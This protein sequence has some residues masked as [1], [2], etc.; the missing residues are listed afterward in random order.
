MKEALRMHPG[1]GFPLERYVPRE[2][3]TICDIKIPPG[4]IVSVSANVI[5]MDKEVF[6]E[7]ADR[8][9][10]ERWIDASPEQLKL[11][12]RSFL[13]VS[14]LEAVLVRRR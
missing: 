5:H 6:G 10:P 9:R 12:D 1:V 2:G 14:V 8:F 4:T 7:D 11:M 3:A 13:A